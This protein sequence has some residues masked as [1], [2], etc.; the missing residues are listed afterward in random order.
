MFFQPPEKESKHVKS[1]H[2]PNKAAR[3]KKK[4][5]LALQTKKLAQEVVKKKPVLQR[6][7]SVETFEISMSSWAENF[8]NAATWQLKHQVAHWKARVKALE[9]ENKVLRDTLWNYY[10]GDGSKMREMFENDQSSENERMESQETA[11]TSQT[12]A[13]SSNAEEIYR[14]HQEISDNDSVATED[15]SVDEDYIEHALESLASRQEEARLAKADEKRREPP[16]E[17]ENNLEML[18]ELYGSRWQRIAALETSLMA[19][20]IS[21]C[22]KGKP[23]Y[24]PNVPLNC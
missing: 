12:T 4:R 10:T 3:R 20:F 11:E 14:C 15:I 18:K 16:P 5:K 8:T 24:W 17:P 13:L 19:N 21:E 2:K 7:Q 6:L 23:A 22:D 1:S 9:Y